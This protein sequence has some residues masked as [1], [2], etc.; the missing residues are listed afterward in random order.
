MLALSLSTAAFAQVSEDYIPLDDI[1]LPADDLVLPSGEVLTPEELWNL[2]SDAT[3]DLAGLD[4]SRL[5]PVHNEI[6]DS[7]VTPQNDDLAISTDS[8]L[9]FMGAK[10]SASGMFRFNVKDESASQIYTIA[11]DKT[12]HTVLL[13]RSFLRLLGYKIPSIEWLSKVTVE[14]ESIEDLNRF[15]D[16]LIPEATLGAPSRWVESV[17]EKTFK[18]TL[19]DV[20][21]FK[22][23]LTDHYNVALG[24]P[25][26]SLTSRTL[27]S[28]LLPYALL[29]V[30]ESVNKFKWHEGRIDNQVVKLPHFT[31]AN[32]NATMDDAK[33][34][35]R[36]MNKL[37]REDIAS[38]VKESRY[39][40]EVELLLTEKIIARRN[41]LN[42]LFSM[43]RPDTKFDSEI[44]YGEVLV[45]GEVKK[46]SWDGYASNFS[47]PYP[48]SPFEDKGYYVLS[49]LQSIGIDE[50][51]ARA[52]EKLEAFD[53][54]EARTE[55]HQEQFKKGLEHFVETG[56]FI[57]F[58]VGTWVSPVV[59]GNAIVSRNVVVG[60]YMGTD[61]LVQLADTF[62][63]AITIGAHMGIENLGPSYSAY[64]RGT[65]S[66]LKTYTHLKP[67]KSL[68]E[69]I[70]E[71]YRNMIVPML[72]SKL[73]SALEGLGVS[74]GDG[75]PTEEDKKK[76]E[77]FYDML[78]KY[79][80]VGESLI[81]TEKLTP[82]ALISGSATMAETRVSL[83][84]STDYITM[85]R[86][87]LNRES[88][89]IIQVY[90]DNGN[91]LGV[92]VSA[93]V[94]H[95]IP[96]ARLSFGRDKGKYKVSFNKVNINIDPE[97][98]PDL[99]SNAIAL[100]QIL[101]SGSAEA[102][103]ALKPP[104]VISQDFTDWNSKFKLFAWRMK[105]ID[106]SGILNI[107]APTGHVDQF[108]SLTD[109]SQSGINY[110]D[111]A[112][113]V[114]NYYLKKLWTDPSN[115][116]QLGTDPWKNP[117]QSIL[118][119]SET[120]T[121]KF[122]ARW[123]SK[124][125]SYSRPFIGLTRQMQ[126]W[127]ASKKKLQSKLAEINEKFQTILFPK[128]VM[129][130]VEKLKLYDI[131][132]NVNFYQK[133]VEKLRN[134]D[135]KEVERA[136]SSSSRRGDSSC[137]NRIGNNRLMNCFRSGVMDY[138]NL[139][140]SQSNECKV[141]ASR[142]EA[143]KEA[144]CLMDLANLLLEHV[145]FKNFK[146]IIGEDNFYLYGMVS[147]FRSKSEILYEPEMSNTVG[148]IT[149]RAW[150]G[151]LAAVRELIGMQDGEM[152]GYWI[153]ERL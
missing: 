59:N 69:S 21:A 130:D 17:D 116:I 115:A 71:P 138:S 146:K 58:G 104:Y 90:M 76:A 89:D 75:E 151:P 43:I 93:S 84:L 96:V 150:N 57:D 61:N 30:R 85:K 46:E 74:T 109:A 147:G 60:Q 27:R 106:G 3:N 127:S 11:L 56:E 134:L 54:S 40:K 68:K 140:I 148:R 52:N 19:R 145:P 97:E 64:A 113:D 25:P 12:L 14:F 20:A 119:L 44:S 124:N 153:R 101:K 51:V 120:R 53:L 128:N 102:L 49:E 55:F 38:A 141:E 13:R 95:L 5:N 149:D 143:K 41:S 91:A 118:G 123:D 65:L 129:E 6:W 37:S 136:F 87:H 98:N 137:R 50:L 15:K 22:P 24:V 80:G 125:K 4:L 142:K 94:D 135:L 45:K 16:K 72:K 32:F 83:S 132:V 35:L 144:K 117:S 81:I 88:S 133:G 7:E 26:K 82:A 9:L 1:R 92:Q 66:Y 77:E 2:R 33:W 28:L 112:R 139:I 99:K 23:D 63:F 34:M 105:T 86:I 42:A 78:G 29:N 39:P 47:H 10:A 110:E 79:L 70:K 100:A 114:A 103:H 108:L 121:S 126:G 111:F 131:S 48:D 73:A 31:Q 107:Q 152:N 122:E 8:K 18:I 67:V 36:K 62:G